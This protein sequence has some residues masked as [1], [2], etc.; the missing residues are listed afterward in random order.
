[1]KTVKRVIAAV[2]LIVVAV[3]VGYLIFTGN[4]LSAINEMEVL[5]ANI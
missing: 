2:L 3:L 4:Q 1:M 5:N